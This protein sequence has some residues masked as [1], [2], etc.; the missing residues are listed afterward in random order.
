MRGLFARSLA[1]LAALA[2]A[3]VIGSA[4]CAQDAAKASEEKPEEEA[5]AKA[6][7]PVTGRLTLGFGD[8]GLSRNENNFRRY[9]TAP[10]HF[11]L[12]ELSLRSRSGWGSGQ[13]GITLLGIAADDYSAQGAA[14][15]FFGRLRADAFMTRSRYLP[16]TPEP[17]PES[18]R[19]AAGWNLVQKVNPS[20]AVASSYT[21]EDQVQTFAVPRAPQYQR[22][23]YWDVQAYGK[24]GPGFL[25]AGYSDTRFNDRTAVQPPT[26]IEQAAASYVIQAGAAADLGA[27]FARSMIRQPGRSQAFVET[28]SVAAGASLGRLG[29]LSLDAYNE[30]IGLTAVATS[31]VSRN[32]GVSGRLQKRWDNWNVEMGLRSR[33]IKRLNE[34]RD[35]VDVPRWL[36]LD[37]R[38]RGRLSRECKIT[39]KGSSEWLGG[40]PSAAQLDTRSLYWDSRTSASARI[41]AGPAHANGY[42]MGSFR[43]LENSVRYARSEASVFQA[44][45]NLQLNPRVYAFGEYAFEGL[46]LRTDIATWPTSQMFA[47]NT[48]TTVVGVAWTVDPRTWFSATLTDWAVANDNPLHLAEGNIHGRDLALT[49]RHRFRSGNE[50]GLLVSPLTYR[51]KVVDTSDYTATVVRVSGTTTF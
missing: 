3:L 37:G 36:T 33:E 15:E 29:D 45:G 24:A 6:L 4:A 19:K 38:L 5:K 13:G 1:V 34:P 46:S 10:R 39:V 17:Q 32:R 35:Y 27:S 41:E 2:P 25:T 11:F 42:V 47:P 16:D 7:L 51:D 9:G 8:W 49:L 21:V 40:A 14:D 31:E 23:R 20:F 18:V 28:A 12:E 44:G 30:R 50:L 43:V 22:T 26:N 48:R